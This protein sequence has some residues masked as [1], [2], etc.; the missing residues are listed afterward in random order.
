MAD[1]RHLEKINKRP[2]FRNG[3][4]DLHEI[5]HGDANWHGKAY[6]QLEFQT[7][8]NPLPSPLLPAKFR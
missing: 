4:P 1:G 3:L 8:E 5:W 6:W 7:S 2:Y